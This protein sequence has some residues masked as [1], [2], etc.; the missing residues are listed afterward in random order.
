MALAV[1][2]VA[3]KGCGMSCESPQVAAAANSHARRFA[4]QTFSELKGREIKSN[5]RARREM[6]HS[7]KFWAIAFVCDVCCSMHHCGVCGG[8][9][10]SCS[11]APILVGRVAW[12]ITAGKRQCPC[13]DAADAN[14]LALACWHIC[15]ALQRPM[16]PPQCHL[17]QL[18]RDFILQLL[19]SRFTGLDLLGLAEKKQNNLSQILEIGNKTRKC[20]K[21]TPDLLASECECFG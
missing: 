11:Y 1:V 5:E 7:S 6:S 3:R 17:Q 8:S 20:W 21:C 12:G 2:N 15:S 18:Q 16:P 10:H 4:T 9:P 14:P 13:G 19:L